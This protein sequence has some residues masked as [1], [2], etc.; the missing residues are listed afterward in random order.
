MDKPEQG[1]NA[2]EQFNVPQAPTDNNV[3]GA[4]A[5]GAGDYSDAMMERPSYIPEKFF[6]DGKINIKALAESYGELEKSR[7]N[8]PAQPASQPAQSQTPPA[9]T[10]AAGDKAGEAPKTDGQNQQAPAIII[11]GVNQTAM[12][13]YTKEITEGGKLSDGSYADLAKLGY[14]KN[15]VDS[16]VKGLMADSMV[17]SA[18]Q[19]TRIAVTEINAITESVGGQQGLE[20]MLNWAATNVPEADLKVYNEATGSADPAKV[21]MAVQG[22]FHAYKQAQGP[23]LIGGRPAVPTGTQPFADANAVVKAME[24]PR[25]D[26][27]PSYREEVAKRLAVSNVFSNSKEYKVRES[28]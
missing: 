11:P 24:D 2:V 26:R 8:Q 21:R 16:Y 5:P 22:M 6:K 18:V 12:E 25:Y 9:G 19:Q 17:E 7:S 23:D 20:A 27:D 4:N 13:H 1:S 15:V 28:Y 3:G 10:P 14:P